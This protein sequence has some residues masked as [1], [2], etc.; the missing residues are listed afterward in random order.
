MKKVLII[1]LSIIMVANMLVGCSQKQEE[2]GLKVALIAGGKFGDN[3]MND[4]LL[5]GM[6]KFEEET[7]IKVTSVEIN[8]FSDNTINARNF[9]QQGYDLIIMGDAVSEI[10][11]EIATEFPDTHFVLNKGTI[12]DMSN[13]TSVKFE[14][15]PAGFLTGAFAV[16]M[17]EEL[18]GTKKTGWI[19]GMRI[20]DL[21]RSR[22]A[23]VA[24]AKYVGGEA[25]VAYVGS[26]TDI[27]KG[28]EIAL[29]MYGDGALMV[30]AYAGAASNG[31]YQA[32]E[33]LDSGYYAMGCATGQFHLSP[34]RILASAVLKT[35]EAFLKVAKDFVEGNLKSGVM[36]LGLSDDSTG[37]KYN[38]E[39]NKLVPKEI[40]DEIESLRQKVISGE[41]IPPS[42]EEEFEIFINGISN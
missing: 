30:Q 29:Q 39:L 15:A 18:N 1:V 4:A 11:P 12:E 36:T 40:I 5:L 33:G 41:I 24:G 20:P 23:F 14:E 13:V 21:E 34:E 38:P 7:G 42:T 31:V 16:L 35:D 9:A 2:E 3:G 28:K 32:V 25:D 10:I 6:T 22:Y 26:F 8:E 19:G 17:S 27:A 37:I